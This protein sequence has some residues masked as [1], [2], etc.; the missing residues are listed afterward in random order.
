[1]VVLLLDRTISFLCCNRHAEVQQEPQYH[2]L[3]LIIAMFFRPCPF[4]HAPDCNSYR[5]SAVYPICFSSLALIEC[6]KLHGRGSKVDCFPN[7]C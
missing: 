4:V 5:S 2:L 6:K 7:I 1:M 3:F